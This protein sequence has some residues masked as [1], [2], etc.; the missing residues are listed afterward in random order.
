MKTISQVSTKLLN[1]SENALMATGMR[2][3]TKMVMRTRM[4]IMMT[5]VSTQILRVGPTQYESFS[6]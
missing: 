5:L 4:A 3:R 1:N 2:T 6:Y